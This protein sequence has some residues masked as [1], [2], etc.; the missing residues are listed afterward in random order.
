MPGLARVLFRSLSCG[1]GIPAQI[2]HSR[3]DA[4]RSVGDTADAQPHLDASKG[5]S[6]HKVV[7]I[8][9][10]A[11]AENPVGKRPKAIAK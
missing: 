7:K 1:S 8:A 6:D 2:I 3:L 4:A 10:M 5:A 9:E 11:D